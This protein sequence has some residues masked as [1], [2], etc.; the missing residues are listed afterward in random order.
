VDSETKQPV[1]D[2]DVKARYEARI[3][4]HTGIRLIGAIARSLE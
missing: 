3:L 4:K 1:R 2:I